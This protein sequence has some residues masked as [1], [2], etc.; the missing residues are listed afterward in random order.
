MQFLDNRVRF[1]YPNFLLYMVEILLQFWNLNKNYFSFLQSYGYINI[2][3]SIFNSAQN[4][5]QQLVIFIHITVFAGVC[6]GWKERLHLIPNK[7][8]VNA[9]LYVETLL[10]ELVQDCRSVLPSGF[11][12]QSM[13]RLHTWQSWLKTRLLPTAVNSLVKMN[14]LQT[15]LTSTLWTTMFGELCLNATSHFNPSRRT[16]MSSRKFCSWYGS[17]HRTRSTKPYWASRKRL[18]ACVKAGDGHFEHTL[19]WTTCQILVFVITVSFL[20]MKITS[21]CWLFHAELKIGHRIVI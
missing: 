21:C 9:E 10:P 8:K 13:A 7:T 15:R 20:T 14:G 17:C 3:C 1:L 11:I 4:N 16:S 12:F 19:I 2:I 18:W 5:Q 6:F